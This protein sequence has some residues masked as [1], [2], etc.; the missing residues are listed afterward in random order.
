MLRDYQRAA[1]QNGASLEAGL[2]LFDAVAGEYDAKVEN[3]ALEAVS[4]EEA[5]VRSS[6]P[7]KGFK[8]QRHSGLAH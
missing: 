1:L 4:G 2:P 7:C 8:H 5:D 6:R 3:L